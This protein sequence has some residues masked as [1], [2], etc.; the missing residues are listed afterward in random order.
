MKNPFNN[1]KEEE[2]QILTPNRSCINS[3]I[4]KRITPRRDHYLTTASAASKFDSRAL[5]YFG[6]EKGIFSTF[7]GP[8]LGSIVE[9][10]NSDIKR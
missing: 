9:S 4:K 1:F 10:A 7:Q 3:N 2:A 8:Q 6:L 5:D